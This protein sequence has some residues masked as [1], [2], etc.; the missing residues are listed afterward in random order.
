[1]AGLR[2]NEYSLVVQAAIGGLGWSHLV[3]YALKQGLLLVP[4]DSQWDTGQSFYVVTAKN[5]VFSS[6]GEIIIN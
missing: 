4:F 5:G 1:M 6:E 3:Q 2:L